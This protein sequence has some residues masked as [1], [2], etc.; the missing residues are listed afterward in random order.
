M[1][2]FD[3]SKHPRDEKG[4][5]AVKG[6]PKRK[7]ALE[8][9]KLNFFGKKSKNSNIT[10]PQT[11][12]ELP[13]KVEGFDSKEL[14]SRPDHVQH[15]IDLGYKTLE[16]YE[17]SAIDFWQNGTGIIYYGHNRGRFYK[18]GKYVANGKQRNVM[19]VISHRKE[20]SKNG[21]ISKKGIIHTF[22]EVNEKK[23]AKISIQERLEKWKK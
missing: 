15:S 10:K 1:N 7:Q 23:F 3:E 9:V 17:N 14:L 8:V 13:Q 18:Y 2:K 22:Y 6:S 16:D 20:T 12:K 5:F 4:R 21:K 19:I 11:L